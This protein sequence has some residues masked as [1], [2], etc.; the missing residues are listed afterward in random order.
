MQWHLGEYRRG[1]QP[2]SIADF[3]PRVPEKRPESRRNEC[4]WAEDRRPSADLLPT[5]SSHPMTGQA[6]RF[7]GSYQTMR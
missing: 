7:V 1:W 3:V 6:A 5:G 2:R 4:L